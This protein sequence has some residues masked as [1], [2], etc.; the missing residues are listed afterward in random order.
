MSKFSKQLNEY[1]EGLHSYKSG[2]VLPDGVRELVRVVQAIAPEPMDEWEEL[3]SP[4]R[5]R[6]RYRLGDR[7]CVMPFLEMLFEYENSVGQYAAI[8]VEGSDVTIEVAIGPLDQITADDQQ[9]AAQADAI[10]YDLE[11]GYPS[12][13]RDSCNDDVFEQAADIRDSM[14]IGYTDETTAYEF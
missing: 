12:F 11:G 10:S 1:V 13:I 7:G 5:L 2:P 3:V 14:N 8:T 6:K 9:Y 4:V